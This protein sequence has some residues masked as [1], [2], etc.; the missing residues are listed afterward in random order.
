MGDNKMEED[1]IIEICTCDRCGK[2]FEYDYEEAA[3]LCCDK[4]GCETCPECYSELDYECP[5]CNA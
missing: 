1:R 5:G 3:G 4:C 2:D